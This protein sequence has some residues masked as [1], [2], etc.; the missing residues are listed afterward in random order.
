MEF[1]ALTFRLL[2]L[3]LPGLVGFYLIIDKLTVH[4]RFKLH[5]ILLY[6]L[7]HGFA[8][9]WAYGLIVRGL[10]VTRVTGAGDVLFFRAI[11]D[12]AVMINLREVAVVTGIAILLG[13]IVAACISHK[14]L[15]RFARSVRITRKFGDLDVWTFLMTSPD[16]SPWVV[17]RDLE[18]D[19]MFTGY[20]QLFSESG[21]RDE[22]FL[23]D[24]TV[25]KNSTVEEWHQ[26]PGLYLARARR[27]LLIEFPFVRYDRQLSDKEE[28]DE[29]QEAGA[30][31]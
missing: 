7:L 25:Y 10:S 28:P 1:S 16:V 15:H 17:V 21:E 23:V 31:S 26:T 14:L 24:V 30:A 4:R 27:H 20:V 18:H 9:N 13:F 3:F 12:P 2:L 19:L 8:S 5:A 11:L 29:T 22:L 6:S